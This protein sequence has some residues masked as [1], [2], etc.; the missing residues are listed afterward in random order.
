MSQYHPRRRPFSL[1]MLEEMDLN[2]SFAFQIDLRTQATS[3]SSSSGRSPKEIEPRSV[4][5]WQ[6]FLSRRSEK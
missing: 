6:P 3:P 4:L 5:T 1:T 2:R